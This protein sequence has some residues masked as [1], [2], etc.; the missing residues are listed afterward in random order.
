MSATADRDQAFEC[1]IFDAHMPSMCARFRV[2]EGFPLAGGMYE[3]RRIRTATPEDSARWD[4]YAEP[5]EEPY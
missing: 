1:L 2:P 5:P 4:K 3:I